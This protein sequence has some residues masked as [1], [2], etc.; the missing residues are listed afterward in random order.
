MTEKEMV[1]SLERQLTLLRPTGFD[2]SSEEQFLSVGEWLLVFEGIYVGNKQHP[3][4]LDP[5]EI[6]ALESY[7]GVD[8]SDLA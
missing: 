7:F 4:V 6:A 5:T 8:M 1:E 3:N 2:L